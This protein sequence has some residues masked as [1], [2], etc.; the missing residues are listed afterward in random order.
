[1]HVL[2]WC[3]VFYYQKI[4]LSKMYVTESVKDSVLGHFNTAGSVRDSVLGT[5]GQQ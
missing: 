4:R 5:A 2:V 1:V 3:R